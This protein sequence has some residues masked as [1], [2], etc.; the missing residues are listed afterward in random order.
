M[1]ISSR[2]RGSDGDR[3]PEGSDYYETYSFLTK[4]SMSGGVYQAQMKYPHP[5]DPHAQDRR[6]RKGLTLKNCEVFTKIS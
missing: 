5:L 6:D 4:L 3:G 2:T 1:A